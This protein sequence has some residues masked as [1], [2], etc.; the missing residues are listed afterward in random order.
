MTPMVAALVFAIAIVVIA[1]A[2]RLPIATRLADRPN[3]RSL[4]T[5]PTPRVGGLGV[6]LAALPIGFWLGDVEGRWLIAAAFALTLVSLAD[7]LSSLT[8]RTRLVCHLGAAVIAVVTLAPAG[9]L[10]SASGLALAALL[11]LL[12][13]WMTNLFNFMD[14]ADGIAG[15]MSAIGFGVLGIAAHRAGVSELAA[16]AFALSAASLG[17]LLFNFPPARV[18]LGDAGAVPLGFLAGALSLQGTAMDAWPGWFPALVFSP[19][20]VDATVTLAR[21]LAAG[22]EPWRAH[23][24]HYYQRLV[25]GGWSKRRLASAAWALMGLAGASALAALEG[26]EMLQCGI[27]VSWALVYVALMTLIDRRRPRATP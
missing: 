8:V 11:A 15:G 9:S 22:E 16:L 19:F 6:M 2:R 3:E 25:L 14:G 27:L 1:V 10:A 17:F 21:R 18:F 7:D 12:I 23:R 5:E 24:S 20:I 4:H 26:P 13:T